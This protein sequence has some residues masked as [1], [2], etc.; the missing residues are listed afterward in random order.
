MSPPTVQKYHT[1]NSHNCEVR[2]AL[3]RQEMQTSGMGMR[4][5]LRLLTPHYSLI[6]TSLTDPPELIVIFCLGRS[7]GG[8]PYDYDRGFNQGKSALMT[9]FAVNYSCDWCSL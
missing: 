8:R 7:N 4:G 2:K 1:L 9:G 3:T 6:L 5:R